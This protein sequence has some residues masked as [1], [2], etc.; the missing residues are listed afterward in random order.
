MIA[1]LTGQLIQTGH[2][3]GNID[4]QQ[5]ELVRLVYEQDPGGNLYRLQVPYIWL[6]I[7]LSQVHDQNQVLKPWGLMDYTQLAKDPSSDD[8]EKFNSDFRVLKSRTL[9]D[10]AETTVGDLHRGAI[11]SPDLTSLKV[12]N[13]H[14]KKYKATAQIATASSIC[15]NPKGAKAKKPATLQKHECT[16]KDEEGKESAVSLEE[17]DVLVLNARGAPAGD[18]VLRNLWM[19]RNQ[20]FC[21]AAFTRDVFPHV[22]CW[23]GRLSGLHLLGLRCNL[24]NV[25][26]TSSV[27]LS[28][29]RIGVKCKQATSLVNFGGRP[30]SQLCG[31]L[32][33]VGPQLRHR[34]GFIHAYNLYDFSI[35]RKIGGRHSRTYKLC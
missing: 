2:K 1:A 21:I 31:P 12:I 34:E 11:V 15:G 6:Q 26:N 29:R 5:L 17:T 27:T 13:R 7:M 30:H 28:W 9:E 14:L 33:G 20:S 25:P 32:I 19:E 23:Q 3:L 22:S 4:P 35:K 8:W 18:A 10:G 24:A 16:V